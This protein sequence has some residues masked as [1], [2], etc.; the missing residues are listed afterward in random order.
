MKSFTN[1]L[2]ENLDIEHGQAMTAHDSLSH[3]SASSSIYNNRVRAEINRKLDV[4]LDTDNRSVPNNSILSPEIGFE[5]IRK[6]LHSHAIDL[7]AIL[8]LDG[9]EGEEVFQ[10]NQFGT[11]YGPLPSGSYG[12]PESPFYLYVYYFLNDHGYY[13]FF[14]EIVNEIELQEYLN[15]EGPEETED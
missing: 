13:E 6:V 8:D 4:I 9:E 11:P 2:T 1:F 10:I 14:A 3:S 15:A 5:R 7:P 12:E